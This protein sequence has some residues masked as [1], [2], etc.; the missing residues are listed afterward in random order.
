MSSCDYEVGDR[1]RWDY[2]GI[3]GWVQDVEDPWLRDCK[4]LV[5]LDDGSEVRWFEESDLSSVS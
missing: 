3:L 5:E 4:Y 1:V 2:A